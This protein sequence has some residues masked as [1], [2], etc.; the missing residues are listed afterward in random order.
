MTV[1][2]AYQLA[3]GKLKNADI[4]D[5]CFDCECIFEKATGFSREKR[6]LNSQQSLSNE[7]TQKLFGMVQRRI[8]LEPLQY[9]IGE[10]DF[11]D[12]TFNV[13]KGVLIPRPETEILVD[14]ADELLRQ[15]SE[16]VVYDLCAGTG[17]VGL[18]I[19]KHNPNAKVYLFEKY[20][21]ALR[22]TNE[23]LDNL[24]L[25]NAKVIKCDILDG[26]LGDLQKPD[27]II[28]NPPY[29]KSDE[30][31]NLQIEVKNE[32]LTALDGGIDGL[33]FYKAIKEKWASLLKNDG[34]LIFECGD[35]Q[36]KDILSIFKGISKE[37]KVIYD[38]NNIDRVVQI[39][40]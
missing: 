15:T 14:L 16:K 24:K 30:I 6:I 8:D 38:F 17:C 37:E 31:K 7:S 4:D 36:S 29:I 1:N 28:S 3:K 19:A 27:I 34:I 35:G 5:F 25:S 33:H 32:P 20:E 11:M 18:T 2:E 22:F 9:I 26:L 12:L 23:N 13:G 39:K 10:W 21:N 40:V